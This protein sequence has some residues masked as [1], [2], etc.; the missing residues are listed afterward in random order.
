MTRSARPADH[1]EFFRFPAPEGRSRESS[2]VLDGEG[3]FWHDGARIEHP[4]IARAFAG[5]IDLHP[6]DGRFILTN[7]WDYCYFTVQDVPFF[8]RALGVGPD[9]VR[10]E[11]SDGSVELLDPVGLSVGKNDAVYA[12]VKG[13]RFEARLSPEAQTR[14]APLLVEGD[15]GAPALELGGRRYAFKSRS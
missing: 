5:W 11:L 12:R 7:G 10:L 3:R 15:G 4:G 2:I 9:A 14:L 8:V 6:D 13:G 1:P